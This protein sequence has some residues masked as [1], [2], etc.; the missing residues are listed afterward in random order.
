MVLNKTEQ[1]KFTEIVN[2]HTDTLKDKDII[3]QMPSMKEEEELEQQRNN[4][5]K[6]LKQDFQKMLGDFCDKHNIKK[7]FRS[8]EFVELEE[9]IHLSDILD[10]QL[11][12]V[13]KDDIDV[14]KE[15]S[16]EV[17]KILNAWDKLLIEVQFVADKQETL[18]KVKE[19]FKKYSIKMSVC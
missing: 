7:K 15:T 6:T 2:A 10:E 13:Y 19:F 4:V 14:S 12:Y 17:N 16:K 1:K 11:P 9:A 18:N 8:F 5:E 3:R